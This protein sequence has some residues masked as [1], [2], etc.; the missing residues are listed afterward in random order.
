VEEGSAGAFKAGA[1]GIVSGCASTATN[2]PLAGA[3]LGSCAV[4]DGYSANCGTKGN[5]PASRGA[6]RATILGLVAALL[7]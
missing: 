2:E 6:F 1:A 7:D 5:S 4:D 3:Q